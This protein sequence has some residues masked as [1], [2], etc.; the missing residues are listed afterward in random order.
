[1]LIPYRSDKGHRDRIFEWLLDRYNVLLPDAQICIGEDPQEPFN[2]ARAR[3]NAFSQATSDTLLVADA[4]T[5]FNPDP[6]MRAVWSVFSRRTWILPYDTYYNVTMDDTFEI[7]KSD[8][9]GSLPRP[10]RWDH[11][12]TTAVS[13]LLVLSREAFEK[14]GGYDER[15]EGW[16]YEDNAFQLALDTL[17]TPHERFFGEYCLHLWHPVAPDGAFNSP[18]IQQSRARFCQYRNAA[19]NPRA[20]SQVLEGV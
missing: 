19:G 10:D 5:V 11:R 12:L 8:P 6:I 16:G 2:R 4:D 20:M 18:T 1:M 17:Y 14:V 15:F 3:N 9:A 7:L 13:G